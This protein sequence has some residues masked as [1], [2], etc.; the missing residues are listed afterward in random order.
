[1]VIIEFAEHNVG[2]ERTSWVE[3]TASEHDA[4]ELRDEQGKTDADW[5]QKRA[6]VLF[7]GEHEAGIHSQK[8]GIECAFL[9]LTL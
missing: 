9:E 6:F 7:G 1:M 3:G 8:G 4:P 5:C 2:A